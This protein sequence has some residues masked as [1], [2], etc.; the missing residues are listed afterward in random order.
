MCKNGLAQLIIIMPKC[1]CHIEQ[2]LPSSFI[3]HSCVFRRIQHLQTLMHIENHAG[4]S[5]ELADATCNP[6]YG[7]VCLSDQVE[8][9]ATYTSSN[10]PG[11]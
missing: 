2:N 11:E 9:K 6:A 4:G 8:S 7:P 10:L 3:V 5:I 1:M